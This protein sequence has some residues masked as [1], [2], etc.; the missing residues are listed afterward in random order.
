LNETASYRA[1]LLPDRGQGHPRQPARFAAE[2]RLIGVAGHARELGQARV[3][4]QRELDEVLESK[5]AEECFRAVAQCL[6]AMAPQGARAHAELGAVPF[7]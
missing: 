5:D 7:A 6:A 1:R 2:V 3:L 4:L